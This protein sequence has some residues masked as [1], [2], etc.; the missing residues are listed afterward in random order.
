MNE[1]RTNNEVVTINDV[2]ETIKRKAEHKGLQLTKT[3]ATTLVGKY[4]SLLIGIHLDWEKSIQMKEGAGSVML[5]ASPRTMGVCSV[6]ELNE[7]ADNLKA[8]AS[9]VESMNDR[10][11]GV[12]IVSR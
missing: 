8:A 2:V 10:L 4:V 11:E 6:E 5:S 12:T 3:G 7:M 1:L 9:I